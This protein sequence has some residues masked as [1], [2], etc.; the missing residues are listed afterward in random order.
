MIGRISRWWC[1]HTHRRKS[2][3]SH[4]RYHCFACGRTYYVPWEEGERARKADLAITD[5]REAEA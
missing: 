3:P 2:W 4:G 1:R 5:L